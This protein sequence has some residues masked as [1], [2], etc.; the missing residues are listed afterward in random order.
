M[1]SKWLNLLSEQ[2]SHLI[3]QLKKRFWEVIYPVARPKVKLVLDLVTPPYN[4]PLLAGICFLLLGLG[5]VVTSIKSTWYRVPV[6]LSAAPVVDQSEVVETK[7]IPRGMQVTSIDSKY[8]YWCK[9]VIVLSLVAAAVY[10]ARHRFQ[11]IP[12]AQ[13]LGTVAA[14]GL[15]VGLAFAHLVIVDEPE[16]SHMAAWIYSQ[17]DG[18]AWYGGDIYTGREYEVPGGAFDILVKDPP[19]FLGVVAPP[20]FDTDLSIINDYLT[21]SGLCFSF[22]VFMGR[23]W[24]SMM[25]G[26]LLLLV[27]VLCTRKPGTPR[28]LSSEVVI[29]VMIRAAFIVVPWLVIVSGRAWMVASS[30]AEARTKYEQGEY[31]AS[32]NVMR[33]YRKFMPVLEFD[34]GL[35]LQEGMLE[36]LLER[37]TDRARFAEAFL[38]ESNGY[39]ARAEQIYQELMD[40]QLTCVAREAARSYFR[41]AI[42]NYNSG[43]ESV[44]L[45]ILEEFRLRYPVMPKANY[46]RLLIAVRADDFDTAQQCL[47]EIYAVVR[48]IGIPEARGYLTSGHQHLAQLSFDQDDLVEVRRQV[49][50]RAEQQP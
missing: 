6:S 50:F 9:L 11:A 3:I 18:L 31:L 46:L 13:A 37:D 34:S 8:E 42:I 40:S 36:H 28:G 43:E 45:N 5:L 2:A 27:G 38:L 44:S 47:Q 12:R 1:L 23:G 14:I 48:D 26:S 17:H 22:W 7:R 49:V 33:N 19:K 29:W 15:T 4:I 25:L 10:I 39:P 41:R 24:A 30:V 20:Y 32:L 35:L 16:L 21:W